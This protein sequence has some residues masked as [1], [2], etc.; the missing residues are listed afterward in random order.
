[1][2]KNRVV[3]TG[4]GVVSPVG[5][6]VSTMW[7]HLIS[8]HVGIGELTRV[9]A[10]DFPTKIAAEVKDFD[11]KKYMEKKDARKMDLF[12][13]FAVAAAKMA[14][15]DAELTIDDSN[16]E[17]TGVWIG[18]GIGGMST[19]ESQYEKF[20]EKGHRRVSPFFIPMMIPDMAAGQ[21]SIQFGAKGINS[22]TVT[23]C[24]SGTNS[25]GD[26]FKVIQRGDADADD[27]RGNRSPNDKY[28]LRWI[29]ASRCFI[30][31]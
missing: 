10:D 18:S 15:D 7:D 14:L 13:Q 3:V 8:G 30:E 16:A 2:T 12:T 22:C 27:Y 19:Y 24:A 6:D 21:V 28:V 9:N 1:M 20:L 5:N 26:A 17:R 11:P 25:I 23:A 29:Y 31:K 4:L